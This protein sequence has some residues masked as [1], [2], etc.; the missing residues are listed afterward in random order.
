MLNNQR[1]DFLNQTQGDA[2]GR[3]L[4][5]AQRFE[6]FLNTYRRPHVS[7]WTGHKLDEATGG[8]VPSPGRG[9]GKREGGGPRKLLS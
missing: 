2:R 6:L 4:H 3:T 1:L 7:R 8:I 9:S 5:V